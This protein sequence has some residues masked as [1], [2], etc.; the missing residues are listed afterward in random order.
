MKKMKGHSFATA[1]EVKRKLLIGLKAI[2]ESAY[3]KVLKT[4]K[5]VGIDVLYPMEI[6]LKGTM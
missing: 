2:T 3:H 5:N 1:E 6:I 4:G